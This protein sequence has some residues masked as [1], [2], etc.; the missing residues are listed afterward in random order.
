[1][2]TAWQRGMCGLL[3]VV[4]SVGVIVVQAQDQ[5]AA[6]RA[7]LILHARVREA[8][9][10]SSPKGFQ[11]QEKTLRWDP[12]QT[13]I[14]ICDMWNQ[15]WCRGATRRVG[16]LAPAMNQTITAARSKGIL[17]I[18]APS[19]CMEAYK[20]HPARKQARVAPKAA[21]LP[22]QIGQWCN[23]IPSEEQGIYPIDQSDGGCDDGPQCPQG[24]PWKSQVASH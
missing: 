20:D 21:N 17:I 18:H 12:A 8:P 11:T 2:R 10:R 5:P 14:I 23:K 22:K 16:E 19:S 1:M 15:H 3:S 7:P 6:P 13:A 9:S 4:A 24:S